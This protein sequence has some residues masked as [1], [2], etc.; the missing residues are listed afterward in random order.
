M[1][2]EHSPDS[3]EDLLDQSY[4]RFDADLDELRDRIPEIGERPDV[5]E[6][7]LGLI[8]EFQIKPSLFDDPG[9]MLIFTSLATRC[10]DVIASGNEGAEEN[11]LINYSV[12]LLAAKHSD[13]LIQIMATQESGGGREY[14][15]DA[16]R[17]VYDT[18]TD[19]ML[20]AELDEAIRHGGLLDGV[21]ARLGVDAE[22]EDHFAVRVLTIG[23]ASQTYGLT[24]PSVDHAQF[25]YT[26]PEERA[27]LERSEALHSDVNAWKEGLEKRRDDFLRQIKGM[28]ADAWVTV[29][30]G[31]QNL[32]ISSALAEKL[33]NPELTRHA[34]YYTEDDHVRDLAMLEHEYTHTQGGLNVDG[35]V[36][37]G[38]NI[39]E[40]RAE[41][42]SGNKQGYHEVKGFFRD[43]QVITGQDMGEELE[44]HVKGG[45]QEQ[46]FAAIANQVGLRELA[47]VALAMPHN[48]AEH[49]TNGLVRGVLA[50][51]GGIDGVLASLLET[52][53]AKGDGAAVEARIEAEAHRIAGIARQ[54]HDPLATFETIEL[55]QHNLGLH[56]VV[57]LVYEKARKII[58][59][60]TVAT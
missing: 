32:C 4:A 44:R 34:S 25:D 3:L 52:R 38:M 5:L 48:Y 55:N 54:S 6:A 26:D 49:H 28:A 43:Y 18:Y 16:L 42:Y 9:R 15:D 21:K 30:N 51:M 37:F 57:D 46:V 2:H 14:S 17:S 19:R 40:L 10:A 58:T 22:N 41:R 35:E 29:L 1:M 11:A 36:V 56:T 24:A 13:P 23:G 60:H 53:L 59:E 39:E 33:L 50:S 45:T 27:E 12:A 47:T 7:G 31:E 20:S 8:D